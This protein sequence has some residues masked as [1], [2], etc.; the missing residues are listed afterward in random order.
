MK[1][2]LIS[3]YPFHSK[4]NFA[5]SWLRLAAALDTV[6]KHSITDNPEEA[7]IILFTEHHPPSDPYIFNLFKN[8]IY[9]K[10]KEKVILYQ[11]ADNPIALVP[12]I[13]PS[14][15][16]N[17]RKKGF[18]ETAPYIARHT[19]NESI[20]IVAKDIEKKFLFS[21]VGAART[22]EIRDKI[23]QINYKNAFLKDTS[24]KNLW[25]LNPL[26]KL[27]FEEEYIKI[28]HKSYFVLCPRGIG[29]NSYRLYEVMEMGL[30]PVI[31]ADQWIPLKGP[32]WEEFSIIIPENEIIN[33]PEILLKKKLEAQ[34]MGDLARENWEQWFSKKASFNV[35]ANLCEEIHRDRSKNSFKTLIYSYG[36]FLRPFHFKNI[37]RYLK[38]SFQRNIKKYM[39]IF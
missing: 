22:H 26:D 21:F 10:Y 39:A 13:S 6:K 25:L 29:V 36:Q 9:K 31:I 1:L 20:R 16:K 4:D 30:P 3:A 18:A 11:D 35:I 24:N 34:K 5:V 2:F 14:I 28:C 7:D 33:I 17:Y 27:K 8:P 37:L 15:E 38:N 19:N 32:N 23:L 12:T